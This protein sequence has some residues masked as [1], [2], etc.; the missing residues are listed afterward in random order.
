MSP[1]SG[2]L[3]FQVMEASGDVY[4]TGAIDYDDPS[5]TPKEYK[6]TV[7]A[8]DG[9]GLFADGVLTVAVNNVDDNLPVF[10]K[11]VFRYANSCNS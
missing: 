6:V 4:L 9:G 7:R 5:F 8:I 3:K 11:A 10:T 1:S 2:T